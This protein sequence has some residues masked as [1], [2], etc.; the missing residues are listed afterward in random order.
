MHSPRL[1]EHCAKGQ[2]K[3]NGHDP[4]TSLEGKESKHGWLFQNKYETPDI[5]VSIKAVNEKKYSIFENA[6]TIKCVTEWLD[7]I[8]KDI[9]VL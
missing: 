9:V 7:D 3:T 2:S 6:S 1:R 5:P 4:G 8:L